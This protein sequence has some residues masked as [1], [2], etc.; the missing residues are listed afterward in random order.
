M[1]RVLRNVH[2]FDPA[3]GLDRT[4]DL[5]IVEGTIAAI[6]SGL[7][8]PVGGVELALDGILAFPGLIDLHTHLR[9]PAS[10]S[11]P[12]EAGE[13]FLS[14]TAA[15]SAGGFVQVV[16]MANTHPV[17]DSVER[18]T[19]A[20]ARAAEMR[21]RGQAEVLQAAALT[22]GLASKRPSPIEALAAAGARVFSDDG[23]SLASPSVTLE[24]FSRVREVEGVVFDHAEDASLTE[25]GVV[26]DGPWGRSSGLPL[27]PACA[28]SI[29]VARDLALAAAAG[30]RL[31]LQHLSTAASL[32]AV[33]AARRSGVAVTFE[34]TPHH[35]ILTEADLSTLGGLGRVNPPL[36]TAYDAQELLK[37]VCDG[38]VDAF[39]TD[40]APHPEATKLAS[41]ASAAPGI[42]GLETAASLTYQWVR[43]GVLNL[44]RFVELWSHGP[45]RILGLDPNRL[46]EGEPCRVTLFD[47][48]AVFTVRGE[49]FRSR[50][51]LTPFEGRRLVGRPVGTL[52]GR[53][54]FDAREPGEPRA[55]PIPTRSNARPDGQGS[56]GM[57]RPPTI[58]PG[59]RAH[60]GP[61]PTR[62][63]SLAH[64]V[65]NGSE[66]AR[67]AR[68]RGASE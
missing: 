17:I 29:Q 59:V 62:I 38:T 27:R 41:L 28:E 42:V 16:A 30:S 9:E 63:P 7:P 4:C 14:G 18:L 32:D 54:G 58:P 52:I 56:S 60:P 6:G 67:M 36:R 12:G 64:F 39:A 68:E 43:D 22:E 10:L 33:R 37:A 46:R 49:D 65:R 66:A 51:H 31:H 11:S 20:K 40:H 61:D 3:E 25:G 8:V 1:D 47:P 21:Q 13:D 23:R 35:L 57:A 5:L 53:S 55:R 48:N 15:A 50:A 34:V 45:S 24:A 2:L 26:S 19:R 44:T